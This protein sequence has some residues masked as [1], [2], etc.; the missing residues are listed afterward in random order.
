M[1]V[2]TRLAA[3]LSAA[4]SAPRVHHYVGVPPEL[5]GGRE[6]RRELPPTSVLLIDQSENGVFLIRFADDGRVAGDTWHPTVDEAKEQATFEFGG[7]VSTWKAV[8]IDVNDV[9]AFIISS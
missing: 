9:V 7:A 5:T 1:N 2:F 4:Q 8:P 6:T 3:K